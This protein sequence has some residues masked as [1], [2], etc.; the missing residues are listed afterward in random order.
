MP[1]EGKSTPSVSATGESIGDLM[2]NLV[3][4]Q[5]GLQ[6][7]TDGSQVRQLHGRKHKMDYCANVFLSALGDIRLRT[8]DV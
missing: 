8:Q 1:F 2:T 6:N 4:W 5:F 7:P 3:E